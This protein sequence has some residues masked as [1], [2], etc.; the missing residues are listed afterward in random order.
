V[1]KVISR[2]AFDLKATRWLNLLHCD[3]SM[4]AERSPRKQ[5]ERTMDAK[6]EFNKLVETLAC[7]RARA[8]IQRNPDLHG[9]LDE[10]LLDELHARARTLATIFAAAI[11]KGLAPPRPTQH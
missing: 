3:D 1:L 2:S 9:K 7:A 6:K 8:L 5:E 11:A 10:D 4:T